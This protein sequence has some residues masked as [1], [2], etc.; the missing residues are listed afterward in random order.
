[1]TPRRPDVLALLCAGAV[2]L[3][4]GA[5]A[6]LV[7]DDGLRR[8]GSDPAARAAWIAD[9]A[10]RWQAGSSFWF[11]VTLTFA[12]SFYALARHLGGAPQWRH[13]AVGVALVAAAVDIVGIVVALAVVPDATGDPATFRAAEGLAHGLTAVTAY[14]LY[15]VAGL[16]LLPG[17]FATPSYRRLGLVA[18]VLW[19]LSALATALLAFDA[20]GL[21]VVFGLALVLY[22]AWAWASAAWVAR[23]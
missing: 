13:L 12:W 7:L 9:H 15:T 5:D 4:A 20:P 21:S 22:A 17:A 18:A 23:H 3:L 11:V 1:V 10:A 14:G 2:N 16:L 8:E 6:A 19:G